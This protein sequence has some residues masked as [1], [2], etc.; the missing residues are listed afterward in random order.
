MRVLL[1]FGGRSAEHDVSRVSAVAAA[2]S[3]DPTRYEVLPVAINRSGEWSLATET[4]KFLDGPRE[5]VPDSFIVEGIKVTGPSV[6][7]Q[8]K[9]VFAEPTA[10]NSNLSFDVVLPLLHGPFGEDG[11]IQGLLELADVPYV[12]SGVVGSAVAMD[13]VIMKRAFVA[14]GLPVPKWLPFRDGQDKAEILAQCESRLGYPMFV[15][16]AN[17]GSSV[18]IS[19]V[20]NPKEFATAVDLAWRYDEWIVIEEGVT[21]R[22]IEVAILGDNPPEASIPGEIIPGSDFYSYSDKYIDNSAELLAPAPLDNDLVIEVQNLAKQAFLACRCESMARVDF[23]YEEKRDDGRP[24]RGF[25]AN[26]VNT[27]PGFTPISMYPRLWKESGLSYSA[28][29][30]RLIDLSLER[31]S[32]RSS[33]TAKSLAAD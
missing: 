7:G 23:F 26:E 28:L 3:L 10:D 13:K 32:R 12:G 29:L 22:E 31:H 15:K 30:N 8:N 6:P 14:E 20:L 17:L 9:L 33:R 24:G 1:L 16:P 5:I 18:G 21:A 19:K 2:I 4:Q 11:T 25:L 27:I